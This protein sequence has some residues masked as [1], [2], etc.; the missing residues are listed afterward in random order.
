MTDEHHASQDPI[1]ILSGIGLADRAAL[2]TLLALFQE[3]G[4]GSLAKAAE[5]GLWAR[6]P[7]VVGKASADDGASLSAAQKG[8]LDSRA[9]DDELRHRLWW[10]LVTALDVRGQTL[11]SPRSARQSASA[12]AV[13]VSERLSPAIRKAKDLAQSKR[14][15]EIK[16]SEPSLNDLDWAAKLGQEAARKIAQARAMFANDAPLSFPTIVEEEFL[17]ILRDPEVMKAV[18][19]L[20]GFPAVFPERAQECGRLRPQYQNTAPGEM[21]LA[22]NTEHVVIP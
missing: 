19:V 8:I 3:A 4:G 9:T 5:K 2:A 21:M 6:L 17:A 7:G 11:F 10:D 20:S 15:A 13:R 22:R 1:S 18:A 12:L 14:E 16:A